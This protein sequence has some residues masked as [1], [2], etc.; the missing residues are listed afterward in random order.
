MV[1][2]RRGAGRLGC[3]ITLLLLAGVVYFGVNV[4]EVYLRYYRYRDAMAQAAR[5]AQTRSDDA[6]RRG[7]ANVADSLG[8]PPAAGRVQVR[9]T[10]RGIA[11]EAT[12]IEIVELPG[13]VREFEFHPRVEHP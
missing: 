4:G 5:F 2:V 12:Y 10:N 9:R 13:T 1:R 6:I 7:L 3:L 11:I 8:L